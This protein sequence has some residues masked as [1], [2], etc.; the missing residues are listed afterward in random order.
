M[1]GKTHITEKK[2]HVGA[3]TGTLQSFFSLENWWDL[4]QFYTK[5]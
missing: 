4:Y 1:P 2:L 3:C 5:D